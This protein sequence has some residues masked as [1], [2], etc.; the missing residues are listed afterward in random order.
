M[1]RIVIAGVS[2]SGKSTVGRLVA[3]RLGAEFLDA[4]DFHPPANVA[5]MRSGVPLDDDDRAGWLARLGEELAARE[6]VV[7]ACSALKRKYRDQLRAAAP[8]VKFVL[9]KADPAEIRHRM[10]LRAARDGHFMPPG[11]LDSQIATLEVAEDLL[12]IDNVGA[13][14]EVAQRALEAC[15]R[16]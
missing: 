13:P 6:S 12:A 3:D 9:L 5:K 4:D 15:D 11:L 10:E 14:E 1:I 7:L 2:G 8:G 16:A